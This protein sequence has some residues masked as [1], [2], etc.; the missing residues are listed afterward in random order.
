[1][2]R[3][4]IQV[5]FIKAYSDAGIDRICAYVRGNDFAELNCHRLRVRTE[6]VR[7]VTSLYLSEMP[8]LRMILLK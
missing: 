6:G 8:S 1:M 3:I 7:Q 4:Y 2:A 5:V